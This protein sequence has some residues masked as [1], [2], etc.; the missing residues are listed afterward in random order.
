MSSP[1]NARDAANDNVAYALRQNPDHWGTQ[2]LA[3]PEGPTFSAVRALLGPADIASTYV[4]ES[5]W[6]YLPMTAAVPDPATWLER[7]DFSIHVADGSQLTSQWCWADFPD[8]RL[9]V[10]FEVGSAHEV[11]GSAVGRLAAPRLAGGFLPVLDNGYTDT[12]RTRWERR[13]FAARVPATASLVSFVSF[14]AHRGRA[15]S[16]GFDGPGRTILRLYLHAPGAAD[17]RFADGQLTDGTNAYLASS[18]PGTWSAP[19]LDIPLD[20]TDGS[21]TVYLAVLNTPAPAPSLVAGRSAHDSAFGQVSGYWTGVVGAGARVDVPEPY[22]VDAL[23]NL[24]VQNLVMGWQQAVANGYETTDPSFAFVP[25]VSTSV[26]ALGDFGFLTKFRDNLTQILAKGQGDSFPN[27]EHGIKMQSAAAYTL[28]SNDPTYLRANLDTFTGW[29]ADFAAQRAADPHGLLAKERIASDLPA[30]AYGVHHQS[31]AWRGLR[32]L[33]VALDAI[34][35]HD[36]AARFRAE[37]DGLRAAL[38]AAIA[39]SASDLPDGSRYVPLSLLDPAAPPP[40]ERIAANRDGGYWNLLIPYALATGILPP[41]GAD[42]R[43]ALRYVT[44]HGGL[45]LG[46][47]RF[48]EP[49]IDPPGVCETGPIPPFSAGV[50]GYD[51]PGVDEQYAYSFLKFLGDNDQA[52]LLVL[53]FYGKLAGDLTPS[54]FVCGEG[55]TLWACPDLPPGSR[56]QWFPPLSANNATYLRALRELLVHEDRDDDGVPTRLHLAPATPR[57]WLAD[58]RRVAVDGLPTLFGPVTY[59]IKSTVDQGTL[60]ATVTPPP[61]EPGRLAPRSVVL[62]VRTPTGFELVSASVDGFGVAVAGEAVDLGRPARAVTVVLRCRPVAVPRVDQA[63]PTVV[64]PA[65]LLYRPGDRVALSVTVEAVGDGTVTGDLAVAA[66]PGWGAPA[67][68][69]FAVASH[70]RIAWQ[71][72]AVPLAVPPG[73]AV[74]EHTVTLTARPDHG[75]A[76]AR[77]LVVDVAVPDPRP[78]PDLIAD[79]RPAGYWRLGEAGQATDS[80]GNGGTGAFRGTVTTGEPG[81]IAGDPDG[82]V[83]LVDGYVEIPGSAAPAFDGPYTL[84]A[85]VKVTTSRQQGLIEK[86]DPPGLHGYLLRTVEANKLVGMA[87]DG[88]ASGI[89]T[90]TTT[91]LPGP[92]RHVA[93]VFDGTTMTLY[94]DGRLEASAADAVAPTPGPA[95]LKLGAR[96]DDAAQRLVGWLDEVAVYPRALTAD[97]L[98]A[99]YVKGVLG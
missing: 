18:A 41:G 46:L 52:D 19:N 60:T 62:H 23:R 65:R 94:L 40:Y 47:T 76:L 12:D 16:A 28:L 49:G 97:R 99:H 13:S 92:W 83:R 63:R 51:A 5:G 79:D 93:A 73:A 42:A 10:T 34:G 67:R 32:D 84:E 39:A 15:G 27:W 36:T 26:G 90:G 1:E 85:W 25:E 74:G 59:A 71:K 9:W 44:D 31:D 43:A 21:A 8:Q 58:G 30:A 57:P 55:T 14:T 50:S 77:D 82:S 69:P 4:T 38:T 29:L 81:A 75:A 91:V 61:A 95:S 35:E 33:A 48:N 17:L 2:L 86:Y 7:R 56:S 72:V 53:A 80:S 66:P 96:G 89:A 45:F 70:G 87:L 54:T 98:R 37:A 11:F 88:P 24:L 20:L 3:R 22:A 64:A 78:Y 68:V 6:Y